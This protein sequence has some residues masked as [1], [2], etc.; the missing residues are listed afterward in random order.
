M[1]NNIIRDRQR[2]LVALYQKEPAAAWVI[3]RAR[4]GWR[5]DDPLHTAVRLGP[6]EPINVP[7]ALHSAVGGESDEAVAGDLL[8]GALA[9]CIDSTLRAAA[10]RMRLELEHLSVDVI[11]EVDVR[12]TLCVDSSVPVGFQKM[13]AKVDVRFAPGSD[14]TRRAMLM[15]LVEHCCVVMRTLRDGVPIDVS[16]DDGTE[17]PVESST[18]LSVGGVA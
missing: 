8:C 15:Q 2:P 13:G 17:A 3:D 18:A 5:A 11:A 7:I 12:G 1:A 6:D 10:G 14:P 16:V 9:T 4:T